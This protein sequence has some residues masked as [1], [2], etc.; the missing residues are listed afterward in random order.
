MCTMAINAAPS[1]MTAPSIEAIV[2]KYCNVLLRVAFMYVKDAQ[3]A[4]D[5]VQETYIKIFRK[6]PG[7]ENEQAEKAWIMR[8]AVN[9][10]KDMLRKSKSNVFDDDAVLENI[11][12]PD[13]PSYDATED[14]AIVEVM[15]LPEKYKDVILMFYY[16]DMKITD[17]AK[18]LDITENT[19]SVRLNRA[20]EMLKTRMEGWYLNE[21]V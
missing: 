13:N 21:D 2:E 9:T 19:V 3:L 12:A 5:A 14:E 10:C 7:F 16:Q 4:E 8:V 1:Q 20:R 18:C 11:P 17:I 6:Y 15:K